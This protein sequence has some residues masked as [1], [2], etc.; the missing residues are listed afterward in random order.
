MF[1]YSRKELPMSEKLKTLRSE[2]TASW[3][4]QYPSGAELFI[5]A[6]GTTREQ[7]GSFEN[8]RKIDYD[9]NLELA[10]AAKEAGTKAYV[11]VSSGGSSSSSMFGYMKMK[12]ELEDAVKNLGFEHCVFLR[13]GLLVGAR[14]DTRMAE[15]AMRSVANV[16]GSVSGNRLKDFWAQDADVVAKAAVRAGL[17]CIEGKE[18]EKIRVLEQ[19]D[20]VRLGRTEWKE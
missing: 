4:K 15:A 9:L 13:P 17:D 6:L 10:K 20:I 5:S 19:A 2:D 18:K 14:N 11:L 8:Q 3:P 16:A 1:A 7:A 12:G